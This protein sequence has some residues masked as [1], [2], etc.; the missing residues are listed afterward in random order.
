MMHKIGAVMY[1]IW[2]L[3]HIKAASLVYKLGQGLEPGMVQGRI[4]QDA[5]FLLFF[6]IVAIVVAIKMNWHN[7]KSGYW[8]N[9]IAVS[10]TDIVF[11]TFV[12]V[13]GYVPLW[14]VLAGP[15]FWALSAIF[16]TVGIVKKVR[17]DS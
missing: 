14:P 5:G 16:S 1:I 7:S 2:G 9:L 8:I 3:L 12:L 11:I 13:P 4:F 10:A 17:H 15:L 6:A